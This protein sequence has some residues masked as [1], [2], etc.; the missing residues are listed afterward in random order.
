MRTI[1]LV[2]AIVIGGFLAACS[3]ADVRT[4]ESYVG[5]PL[6]RPDHVL[7]SYFA[8]A[9]EQVRLDQGVAARIMRGAG[10]Q[11]LSTLEL[12]AAQDTQAALADG[13]WRG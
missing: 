4:V 12:R 11:S 5:P 13:L 6:S 3:H 10:D 2:L 9:P 1:W 8:I 7:V